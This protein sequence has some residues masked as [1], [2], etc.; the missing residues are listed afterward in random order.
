MIDKDRKHYIAHIAL[1]IRVMSRHGDRNAEKISYFAE[2]ITHLA[3]MS[4][5]FIANN[6]EQFD[7]VLAQAKAINNSR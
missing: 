1:A 4:D 7:S 5:N 2:V 3:D 6:K